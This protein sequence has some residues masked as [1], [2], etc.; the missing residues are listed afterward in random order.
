MNESNL[1]DESLAELLSLTVTVNEYGTYYR[2]ALGQLH[3][4]HGPAMIYADGC[5]CWMQHGQRHRTDGPAIEF[6]DGSSGWVL[7]GTYL[8]E[9]E[10]NARVKYL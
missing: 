1:S 5:K 6:A 7:H 9:K 3:R 4:I 2:N 8:S 10:W